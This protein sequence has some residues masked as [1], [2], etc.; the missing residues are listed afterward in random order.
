MG[1]DFAHVGLGSPNVNELRRLLAGGTTGSVDLVHSGIVVP[2]IPVTA[3]GHSAAPVSVTTLDNNF[4]TVSGQSV[5]LNANSGSHAVITTVRGTTDLDSG[6]ALFEVTDTVPETVTLNA[7]TSAGAL[8]GTA[9]VTFVSPPAASGGISASPTTVTADGV[10]TTGITVTLKDANGNPSPYKVVGLAQGNGGSQISAATATTDSTGTVNFI[11]T[12]NLAQTVT[13]TATDITDGNLPVPGSAQV[14]F[15]NAPATPPCNVGLGT[16]AAGYA[17]STF[18]SGFAYNSG[19][20]FGPIGLAFDPQGNLLVANNFTGLLYQFSPQGGSADPG[21]VVGN[22]FN[23]EGLNGLVFGKDGSLYGTGRAGPVC[24][25]VNAVVQIDPHTAQII[26]YLNAPGCPTGIAVDPLSGDL[27]ISGY[28]GIFRLSNFATGAGTLTNYSSVGAD[29]MTFAPDG[30]LYASDNG[31]G[32][33]YSI[34]GTN[35]ATPG[36]ATAI[37]T[38]PGADGITLVTNPSS[39]ALPYVV[40]N[41]NAGD[42]VKIDQTSSPA[43]VTTI[44]SGGSRG[45]F[46]TVGP[47]ACMYAIQ[48]DRVIKITNAD[49]SCS[50]QPIA[51][52]PAVALTP[53]VVA[54]NP[55]QGSSITLTAQLQNIANPVDVPV[56]L[57]V[58][59]ANPKVYAGATDANGRVTFTL[60]G[61]EPGEDR[62][63]AV[64][65]SNGT[66]LPSNAVQV[67]WLAGPHTTFIALNQNPDSGAAGTPMTLTGTLVDVSAGPPA[68]LSSQT[69]E[70]TLDGQSCNAATDGTGTASC[71]VTPTTAGV[72]TLSAAFAGGTSYVAAQATRRVDILVAATLPAP[73]VSIGVSPSSIAVGGSATLTWSSSN[74]SACTA[75][76]AWSGTQATSGNQTVSPAVAGSDTYTLSCTGA[77]GTASASAVLAATAPPPTATIGVN[78][79]SIAVGGRATLTWSSTNASACTASGA[80]SGTQATSGSQTVSPTTAGTDTYTL[81]CT[82]S[83]GSASASAALAAT[84]VSVTVAAHSGGGGA[85]SITVLVLLGGLLALRWLVR[86]GVSGAG[87]AVLTT[88]VLIAGGAAG[89]AHAAAP[90]LLDRLY[91]GVRIGSMPLSMGRGRIDDALAA[92]GFGAVTAQQSTSGTGETIY[93]GVQLS[94]HNAFEIAYTNRESRVAS[95]AGTIGSVSELPTLLRA[96]AGSL[97][98]YGSIFSASYRARIRLLNRLYLDPRIGGF[99]WSTREHVDGLGTSFTAQHRGGGLTAGLGLSYRLWRSLYAGVG[100][101]YFR[102]SPRNDATLYGG[103]LEWRFGGNR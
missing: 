13:Y 72:A 7:S 20:C 52:A 23:G 33:V 84:L 77:G 51:V 46:V 37:A 36:V 28:G 17:V 27:F 102:G 93:L 88:F 12:D 86:R 70:F 58:T 43:T 85:L 10:S 25:V 90:T 59:G 66:A 74:A 29:G 83:S 3:D 30:T 9:M 78:P 55:T 18:A 89:V 99:Y 67:Q 45:D 54:P 1:S 75:S 11:A 80:W 63:T 79:T 6:A 68:A 100:A 50:F 14:L 34:T 53:A 49:G 2:P 101:D 95:L 31:S 47:D 8:P 98:G 103:S 26:R 64:I 44:Y 32:V 82:G 73:T 69:I 94:R 40:V 65:S 87:R 38:V 62:A 56:Q 16:A 19:L 22:P 97:R 91:L 24:V 60:T 35:S 4:Y 42:I 96:T 48:T 81:T 41:S 39:A 71:T 5:T 15:T 57:L 92:S 21:H 61:V 76:G